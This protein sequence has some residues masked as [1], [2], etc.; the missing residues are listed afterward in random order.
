MPGAFEIT[1]NEAVLAVDDARLQAMIASD[2]DA[3]YRLSAAELVFVHA[4][5]R[6]EDKPDFLAFDED[7]RDLR[8]DP[9]AQRH[10]EDRRERDHRRRIERVDQRLAVF[11][12]FTAERKRDPEHHAEHDRGGV[13]QNELQRSGGDVGEGRE[14]VVTVAFYVKLPDCGGPSTEPVLSGVEGL[15][16]TLLRRHSRPSFGPK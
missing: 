1:G 7:D 10:D 4:N 9:D 14:N 8:I 16:M 5:G 2:V 12:E 3:L 13:A 15:G 6:Q 11:P